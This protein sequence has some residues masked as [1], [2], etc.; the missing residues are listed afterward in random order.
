MFSACS[1]SFLSSAV[2]TDLVKFILLLLLKIVDRRT[3][4]LN[5]ASG[6]ERKFKT[7]TIKIRLL[8][9]S[10]IMPCNKLPLRRETLKFSKKRIHGFG[11]PQK[12]CNLA[13]PI[14]E[15]SCWKDR[16]CDCIW[17]WQRLSELYCRSFVPYNHG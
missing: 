4:A 1:L 9:S 16:F 14:V 12:A 15:E 7:R 11:L 13:P 6:R 3:K 2:Q 8:L 10:V 17:C 5:P